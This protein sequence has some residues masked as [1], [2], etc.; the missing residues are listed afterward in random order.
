MKN[1]VVT[2]VII[3]I[4]FQTWPVITGLYDA[5]SSV[6]FSGK[7]SGFV[8]PQFKQEFFPK[9]SGLYR[10]EFFVDEKDPAKQFPS[11]PFSWTFGSQGKDL[12][13]GQGP[14][15]FTLNQG[16]IYRIE[17][18]TTAFNALTNE[19]KEKAYLRFAVNQEQVL[20]KASDRYLL[21]TFLSLIFA[22]AAYWFWRK[23]RRPAL[24]DHNA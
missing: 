24:K 22:A 3:A 23:S 11:P 14:A 2:C 5:K 1:K 17:I 8:E 13:Q 21:G 20:K 12:N 16:Q 19:Q 15:E 10:L 9:V 18:D 6:L 7:V 4:F